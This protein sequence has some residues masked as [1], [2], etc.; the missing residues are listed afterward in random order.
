MSIAAFR[1]FPDVQ[2]VLVG[3]LEALVGAAD[4]TGTETPADFT[5]RTP[6]IRV[7]RVP[8][9]GGSDHVDDR[10]SIDIDV[11]DT[12]YAA[13]I[14]LAEQV[15]QYLVGPPPPFAVLDKVACDQG[16]VELPWGG[17]Q[18]RRINAG[19]LVIARRVLIP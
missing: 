9:A 10:S 5:G 15:R 14:R 12:T 13:A 2:A 11:F 18:I 17:D 1:G 4:R 7:L 8:G 3:G 16:P 6:F 19:Y